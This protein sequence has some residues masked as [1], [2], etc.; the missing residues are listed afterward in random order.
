MGVIICNS[1]G[2]LD[3]LNFVLRYLVIIKIL[4]NL[5]YSVCPR[6]LHQDIRGKE[7][8]VS[9]RDRTSIHGILRGSL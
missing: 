4:H 7:T 9:F 6:D 1:K 8:S 2:I 5:E 3:I